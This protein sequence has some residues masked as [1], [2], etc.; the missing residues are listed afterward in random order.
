[1]NSAAPILLKP[2]ENPE[3]TNIIAPTPPER[4]IDA[5]ADA[6]EK[7]IERLSFGIGERPTKSRLAGNGVRGAHACASSRRDAG[8]R[9][10]GTGQ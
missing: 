2:N 8:G 10:K 6:A 4:G 9:R 5:S 3:F 1:V 7:A